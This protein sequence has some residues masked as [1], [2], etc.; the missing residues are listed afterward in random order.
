MNTKSKYGLNNFEKKLGKLTIG[1][2]LWSHRLSEEISA[3]EMAKLLKISPSSL[4][5]LEKGRRIPSPSRAAEI[6]KKLG[7][8]EK[9]WVQISLQD[10]LIQQGFNLKVSIA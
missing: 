8:S 10:Q 6:A 4:C 2:M 5:D 1:N 9:L 7:L 3:K